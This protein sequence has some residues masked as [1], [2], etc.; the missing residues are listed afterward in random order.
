MAL[1]V[2][3]IA[4]RCN[5]AI[6]EIVLILVAFKVVIVAAG[7]D[8]DANV[9]FPTTSNVPFICTFSVVIFPEIVN[10]PFTEVFDDAKISIVPFVELSVVIIPLDEVT[11]SNNALVDVKFV[12]VASGAVNDVDV[13]FPFTDIGLVIVTS[14]A[15]IIIDEFISANLLISV[16]EIDE[17]IRS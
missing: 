7:V 16:V 17:L 13:I 10:C 15:V 14:F 1:D 9:V 11:F 2:L 12:I 8:N 6:N 3:K 4:T 5:V